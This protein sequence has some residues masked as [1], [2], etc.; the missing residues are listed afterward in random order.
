MISAGVV[1]FSGGLHAGS[2]GCHVM[3]GHPTRQTGLC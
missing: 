1:A 3:E 2:S